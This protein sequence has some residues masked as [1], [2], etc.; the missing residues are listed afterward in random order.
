M[1]KVIVQ[2]ICQYANGYRGEYRKGFLDIVEQPKEYHNP[3]Y[4]HVENY[5]SRYDE[6][7]ESVDTEECSQIAEIRLSVEEAT[8]LWI[9]LSKALR[10]I[11]NGK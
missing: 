10:S 11:E 5:A 6:D 8:E 3:I 9:E 2:N 1:P 7:D 4:I